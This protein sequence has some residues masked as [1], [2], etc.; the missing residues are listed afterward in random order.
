[1]LGVQFS[2]IAP[3]TDNYGTVIPN[4][5]GYEI[6]VGNRDG[7]K[8]IIAKGIIRN[9]MSYERN[10]HVRSLDSNNHDYPNGEGL[11]NKIGPIAARSWD[12]T[13]STHNPIG[14]SDINFGLMPN[15]PYNDTQTDPFLMHRGNGDVDPDYSPWF[16]GILGGPAVESNWITGR[17]TAWGVGKKGVEKN[18]SIHYSKELAEFGESRGLNEFTRNYHTFHSPDLNFTHMYLAPSEL[19]VYKTLTGV[20][21]GQ[22]IKSAM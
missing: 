14:Q 16:S 10:E 15:Y 22:F 2:N 9:M 5:T 21:K 8:S 17:G 3:P 19:V 13:S 7:N 1:M 6:L 18:A 4:I 12:L 20:Q 11:N